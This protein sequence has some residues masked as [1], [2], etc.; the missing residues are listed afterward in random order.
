MDGRQGRDGTLLFGRG[1]VWGKLFPCVF[2]FTFSVYLYIRLPT[3]VD[4]H[5]EMN[6]RILLKTARDFY[7]PGISCHGGRPLELNY[8]IIIFNLSRYCKTRGTRLHDAT[9]ENELY[10][11][12]AGALVILANDNSSGT[13]ERESNITYKKI[14]VHVYAYCTWIVASSCTSDIRLIKIIIIGV[15][16]GRLE[17][18]KP[19]KTTNNSQKK[20][21]NCSRLGL[22][23]SHHKKK[24]IWARSIF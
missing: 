2:T 18:T 13:D 12:T 8:S 22:K 3:R 14:Y 10:C 15:G 16:R 21:I 23:R 5:V 19:S 24:L 4:G 11:Y 7:F 6:D 17:G 20:F 1:E 9:A